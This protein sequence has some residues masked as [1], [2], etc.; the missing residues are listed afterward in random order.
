MRMLWFIWIQKVLYQKF[1]FEPIKFAGEGDYDINVLKMITVT[2]S[3]HPDYLLKI[4]IGW[5]LS[6]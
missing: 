5:M 4:F 6:V 1:E 3:A 2:D